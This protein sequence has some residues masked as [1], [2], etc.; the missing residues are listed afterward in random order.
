[1]IRIV[2]ADDHPVVRDGLRALF[3]SFDE[4]EVVAEASTGPE[5]VRA[6]VLE[7]PDVLLMDVGMPRL[8]GLSATTEVKRVAPA[9]AVLVLTMSDDDE[10]V[11]AAM[12]A[13][14]SGYLV[15]GATKEEIMRAVSA[16]AAGGM[17]FGA[18]VARRVHSFFIDPPRHREAFPELTSREREVLDLLAGGLSNSAIGSR[19]GLSTKTVNNHT[20]TIF[21]KLRVAGRTEA[22]IVAREAGLGRAP[23]AD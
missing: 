9:T 20:S 16:V 1:M 14:A 3:D 6:A 17:I 21:G 22:V 8:D 10:T 5:A 11:V 18:D 2:L 23:G 19:L 12:R 7:R 15:K 13:G 4:T